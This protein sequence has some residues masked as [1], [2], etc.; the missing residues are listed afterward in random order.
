MSTW[1]SVCPVE[2]RCSECGYEYQWKHLLGPNLGVP[3]WFF[4]TARRRVIRAAIS[5]SVRTLMP[6]HFWRRVPL[7][8]PMSRTRLAG[9]VIGGVVAVYLTGVLALSM[10]PIFAAFRQPQ[11][12][13]VPGGTSF[14]P[15]FGLAAIQRYLQRDLGEVLLWPA[16]GMHRILAERTG[17][18]LLWLHLV[19][20]FTPVCFLVI[21]GT[22]RTQRVRLAHIWRM[23]AYAAVATSTA[24]CIWMFAAGL[25]WFFTDPPFNPMSPNKDIGLGRLW[26]LWP[27]PLAVWWWFACQRYI[28]IRNAF[29]VATLIQLAAALGTTLVLLPVIDNGTWVWLF[30]L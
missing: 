15:P 16:G 11:M 9:L 4:E 28:G 29:W 20:L 27:V 24:F 23:T 10:E 18:V 1:T 5:T 7:H 17:R 14:V 12:V 13:F 8:A 19:A 2:G 30:D 21:R 25:W 3:K 6:W 22:L 26:I